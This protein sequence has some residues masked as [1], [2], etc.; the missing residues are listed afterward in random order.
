MRA[1]HCKDKTEG[2]CVAA[3]RALKEI[4]PIFDKRRPQVVAIWF[5]EYIPT[6]KKFEELKQRQMKYDYYRLKYWRFFIALLQEI[7]E[8]GRLREVETWVLACK[9]D[10]DVID[11]MLSIVLKA[12]GQ[13]LRV[14]LLE[15]L[16]RTEGVG[17]D[18]ESIQLDRSSHLVGTVLPGNFSRNWPR[19][20]LTTR[21]C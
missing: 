2:S 17:M 6:A 3:A 15:V 5:S 18:P 12:R 13:V 4:A 8:Y 7:A 14:R 19:L 10:H 20:I 11:I 1:H 9:E 16:N 21:T